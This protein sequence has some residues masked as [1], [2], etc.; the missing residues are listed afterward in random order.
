MAIL[1]DTAYEEKLSVH[2]YGN[3]VDFDDDYNEFSRS[4]TLTLHRTDKKLLDFH[5]RF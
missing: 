1:I 5:L 3:Y 2:L 4:F